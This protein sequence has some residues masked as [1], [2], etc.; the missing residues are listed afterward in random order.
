[1]HLFPELAQDISIILFAF[2]GLSS[3]F[4]QKMIAEFDRYHLANQ[5]ILTAVLQC[6]GSLG[7]FVGHFN[8]SVLLLSASGLTIMMFLAVLTRFR[9]RDP[10]YAA[11]PAFSLF[12]LNLYIVL[13]ALHG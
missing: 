10:L 9:I 4:S 11:I 5:R 2:Y 12:A 6:A 13:A 3:F 8:R 1:M 7:L